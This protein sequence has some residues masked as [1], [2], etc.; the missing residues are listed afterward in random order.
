MTDVALKFGPPVS[1]ACLVGAQRAVPMSRITQQPEFLRKSGQQ[2]NNG[3]Q[4]RSNTADGCI[5]SRHHPR[6]GDATS[7]EPFQSPRGHNVSSGNRHRRKSGRKQIPHCVRN[8]STCWVTRTFVPA[9][10]PQSRCHGSSDPW[11]HH[12]GAGHARQSIRSG[13]P[14]TLVRVY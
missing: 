13:G 14:D 2:R 7:N 4:W 11:R 8:D 10:R 5:G 9:G 6:A 1:A 3:Q 12:K